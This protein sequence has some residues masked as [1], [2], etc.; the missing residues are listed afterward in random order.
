MSD[1]RIA[2]AFK[3]FSRRLLGGIRGPVPERAPA[4]IATVVYLD[5][6][7]YSAISRSLEVGHQL[8]AQATRVLNDQILALVRQAAAD[9]TV[10][11]DRAFV[12]GTGDGAILAFPTPADA[13]RFAA[14]LHERADEHSRQARSETEHRCFRVGIYSGEIIRTTG[15]VAGLAVG[16]A[17]RLEA[18]GKTGQILIDAGSWSR[19]PAAQQR[20]YGDLETVPGKAHDPTFEIHRRQV[21]A[22]APWD[23]E[24]DAS[25]GLPASEGT[26][27]PVPQPRKV[28]LDTARSYAELEIGL[29]RAHA[30]AHRVELRF[31]DPA[32]EVEVH[33]EWGTA[34]LDLAEIRALELDD[35]AY[36]KALAEGL[37]HDDNV[38]GLY[39]RARTAGAASGR[40]LRLRLLVGPSAAELGALRWELLHD[41]DTGTPVATCEN[42]FFSRFMLSRD[43]RAVE[44]RAKAELKA[45]IAVA[46][47]TDAASYQ[48]A[49]IDVAGE[50]NRAR[51][52]LCAA[53]DSGIKID[54]AG[55]DEPLTLGRLVARLRDGSGRR[56]IDVLYLVCHGFLTAAQVPCILL[57]DDGGNA[58]RLEGVELARAVAELRRPPRLVVLLGEATAA[59]APLLAEAGVPAIL[60][61]QAQISVQTITGLMPV[62][63][64][65]LLRDGQ[66]DR[67]LAA[68]RGAVRDRHDAWM[69]ALCL[70]LKRGCIWQEPDTGRGRDEAVSGATEAAEPETVLTLRTWPPPELPVEPYPVL[71]PYAHPELMAGREQEIEKLR[72]QLRLPVPILGLG[73]TSGTGK[74]SLLLAGLVPRLRFSGAMSAERAPGATLVAV[75]R[76]PQEP[77]VAGRLLGDL[78][79]G[80]LDVEDDDWRG[81]ARHLAEVERLAGE[82]PLLV[83]DQFENV[84]RAEAMAARARLGPLLAATTR[85]R[86]GTDEPLCRWLL[87]YRIEYHGELLAWLEDVLMEAK[88]QRP[89]EGPPLKEGGWGD[90]VSLPYDLSGPDRFLGL[91]VAPLATPPPAGDAL[92]EATRVFSAA[93]EKPLAHYDYRFR[94]GDAERLA[95]AFAEARLA[96][97]QAPLVTELQVVLAHLLSQSTGGVITVPTDPEELVEEALADH[98]RRALEAAF[99][100]GSRATGSRATG[101]T[102]SATR[103]ARA[104]LALRR[105]ATATGQRDEGVD[106]EELARAIG[107]DGELILEQLSTPLTRLVILQE[108][109]GGLRYVLSHDRMAEVVVRTVEEEGRHGKLLVD[110]ELLRLRRF[111]ALETA[112]YRSGEA[113]APRLPRRRFLALAANTEA[114]LW[115]QE[116]RAWWAACRRRRRADRR[117]VATWSLAGVAMLALV[118]F[119]VWSWATARAARRTLLDQ[120]A[121]GEPEMALQA[122]D[123]LRR[124]EVGAGEL[125]ALLRRREVPSAVLERGLGG[126]AGAE[127]GAA[128]LAAVE[129][130]MPLIE[131][132][133]EDPVLIANLVWALDFAPARDPPFAARARESRGRV[134]APLRRLRPPPPMPAEGDPDWIEIPGGSFLMG[135]GEDEEGQDDERPRHEVTVSTFRLQRH[136]VTNGEYRRLVPDHQ[137][138]D[139][140]PAQ[141]VSWYEAITYAAWLGGRLPTEVE[142]EYAARAGCVHRYCDGEGREKT[143]DAVAWTVRNSKDAE[144]GEP[145]PRR[146]MLLAPNPWGLYDMLGNLWEWTADWYDVYSAFVPL[147]GSAAEPQADPWGPA[148]PAPS[149]GGRVNRGG[150]F[151]DR[152]VWTR[153]ANRGRSAPDDG[154]ED[155]GFRVM[156]LPDRLE[157]LIVDD[158]AALGQRSSHPAAHRAAGSSRNIDTRASISGSGEIA[159]RLFRSRAVL[160]DG[161]SV[162]GVSNRPDPYDTQSV[163][164]TRAADG[165]S[166]PARRHGPLCCCA[167]ATASGDSIVDTRVGRT[168]WGHLILPR[169]VGVIPVRADLEDITVDV[170]KPPRIGLELPHR[171]PRRIPGL[172][173]HRVTDPPRHLVEARFASVALAVRKVA[174]GP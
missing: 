129:L 122:L 3:T 156:L 128:V 2:S 164:A 102:D 54:V 5:L 106:A 130:M 114:L 41:L 39:I 170:E 119:G 10:D 45:L 120:V 22:P 19:L 152:A 44:L 72:M 144:T 100:T 67:A 78:A 159:G 36:G 81:F 12:K 91:T 31:T 25:L 29:H 23:S 79:S 90:L 11:F 155:R 150:S 80:V 113:L 137:D 20:R 76:H 139:D 58:A 154:Y 53:G 71:L 115:D 38:R 8:G 30:G 86:P 49:E 174:A 84:L 96:V 61:M 50:V 63:F 135:T 151:R 171:P 172:R 157:P 74:S 111:V 109:Q 153:V 160:N 88:S 118:A 40:S 149:G 21:V 65:E 158:D 16:F 34:A 95:L 75:V 107:E 141:Y 133:P 47:P 94:T 162:S 70:R 37:F 167:Y 132:T 48:L 103:R 131:E 138:E 18:A 6:S 7:R 14:A 134:L 124:E 83:L 101:A 28:S 99:P 42:I 104:L 142:W 127:R 87:A 4:S 66:I 73:A 43:W 9:A 169:A 92:A 68:A 165:Q 173:I 125:L 59:L 55:Q 163:G 147:R 112:L 166:A 85:R 56:G 121:Q 33:P 52:S 108:A 35:E 26:A 126:L 60:A 89:S 24:G 143:V 146:V 98:L 1:R 117:R 15:D 136:E 13:E 77:G 97:P 105:L 64:R 82:P 123:Q 62:F 17:A 46:A 140:L 51:E 161:G 116:R 32:S 57:Q 27:G 168:R 110:A 145:A 148:G 69:P 93:I